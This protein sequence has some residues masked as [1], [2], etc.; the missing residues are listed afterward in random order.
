[1]RLPIPN[2]FRGLPNLFKR[3][4]GRQ[5]FSALQ[6]GQAL[7][8]ATPLKFITLKTGEVDPNNAKWHSLLLSAGA[9]LIAVMTWRTNYDYFVQY[10]TGHSLWSRVIVFSAIEIASIGLPLTKGWGNYA[11]MW[12]GI[13]FDVI[14]ILMS[15]THTFLV[16]HALEAKTQAE[17][18][19]TEAVADFDRGRRERDAAVERNNEI[20]EAYNREQDKFNRLQLTY[21]RSA[22]AYR[23]SSRIARANNRAVADPPKPPEPPKPPQYVNVPEIRQTVL[24][25]SQISVAQA[26]EKAVKHNVL[27][28][29]LFGMIIVVI[30]AAGTLVWLSDSSK[31]KIWLLKLR[32]KEIKEA[33]Q[34]VTSSAPEGPAAPPNG[35]YTHDS[36]GNRAADLRNTS[37]LRRRTSLH[38]AG[39]TVRPT[40]FAPSPAPVIST[41]GSFTG[42][43][44]ISGADNSTP[45]EPFHPNAQ[46][47]QMTDL[48][49]HRGAISSAHRGANFVAPRVQFDSVQVQEGLQDVQ[50]GETTAS[51][52]SGQSDKAAYVPL[53]VLRGPWGGH[54]GPTQ[55]AVLQTGTGTIVIPSAA[56][57]PVLANGAGPQTLDLNPSGGL[58]N[59]MASFPSL[60]KTGKIYYFEA[61][62]DGVGGAVKIVCRWRAAELD[63][64][65]RIVKDTFGRPKVFKPSAYCGRWSNSA[66]RGLPDDP[67]IARLIVLATAEAYLKAQGIEPKR[68]EQRRGSNQRG[69]SKRKSR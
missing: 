4:P 32:R 48:I 34:S 65:G 8:Q 33:M 66:R 47:V 18:A 37:R 11:Q 42:P 56:V 53:R 29:L 31:I 61:R 6:Y 10:Y 2:F 45:I 44:K 22:G 63:R 59:G 38:P 43:N 26:S 40:N 57:D 51:Q 35:A 69:Q 67:E 21:E 62:P 54:Q 20:R 13:T 1:M 23:I 30:A 17:Y 68:E 25:N 64:K 27:L 12:A 5:P 60:G 50:G 39:K 52:T 36:V 19:K 28:L 58:L 9:A 7:P 3:Q 16:S 55:G 14:L 46:P 41:A 15:I 24:E 49:D